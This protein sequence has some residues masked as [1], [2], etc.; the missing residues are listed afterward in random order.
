MKR[1]RVK[2]LVFVDWIERILAVQQKAKRWSDCLMPI[3]G[4]KNELT[5]DEKKF[6]HAWEKKRQKMWRK[7]KNGRKEIRSV[8]VVVHLT[9]QLFARME[10]KRTLRSWNENVERI[11]GG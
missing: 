6:W 10:K 2:K 9:R 3:E 7:K 5:W 1:A 8:V 4:V 11:S